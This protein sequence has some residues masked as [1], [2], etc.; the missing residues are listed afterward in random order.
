MVVAMTE[1]LDFELPTPEDLIEWKAALDL[2][3]DMLEDPEGESISMY[4]ED[5]PDNQI[6][7]A[8]SVLIDKKM[9]IREVYGE[10]EGEIEL[11]SIQALLA[12]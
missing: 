12:E 5:N 3:C 4:I 7:V 6:A 1:N 10:A 2:D 9:V 11:P 8:V